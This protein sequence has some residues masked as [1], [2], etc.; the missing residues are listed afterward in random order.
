MSSNSESSGYSDSTEYSPLSEN[1]HGDD[2]T[3]TSEEEDR[4]IDIEEVS[5]APGAVGDALLV[6]PNPDLGRC[7]A[8]LW[9]RQMLIPRGEVVIA[10][11]VEDI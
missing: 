8:P 10:R 6:Q 1:Q 7:T 5:Q 4:P 11:I 2:M 9:L 3:V